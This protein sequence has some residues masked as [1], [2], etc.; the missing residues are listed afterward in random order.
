VQADQY[1]IQGRFA[2]SLPVL[3]SAL[4]LLGRSF[5]STDDEAGE[6]FP[7]E[8]AKTEEQLS[9]YDDAELL[10]APEMTRP[11]VLLEMRIYFAL[12]YATY[13]TGKFKSF[14]VDACRMVQT[15][16]AYGSCDLTC[17]GYVAYLT[18]MSAMGR[19]YPQCYRMGRLALRLAEKRD[20]KYFRLTVYQYFSAFYQHWGE[21]LQATL[22]FLDRGVEF[23]Q[24]GI[25]PLAGF[26]A[27]LR[28]VNRLGLGSELA[29]P[30]GQMR[31]RAEVPEEEPAARDGS[32]AAPRRPPAGAALRARTP[33]PAPRRA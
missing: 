26:C 25:N 13:Q 21:S 28:S 8:F 16:L 32:H 31:G 22:P 15:G 20:S 19:P 10:S 14:V 1:Q 24:S 23:G 27:L 5:P 4:S 30:R 33:D 18:A 7:G 12:S 17:V 11:E 6:I 2:E 9:R 3:L 29:G